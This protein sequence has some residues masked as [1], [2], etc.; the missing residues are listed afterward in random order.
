[1]KTIRIVTI[2]FL[3]LAIKANA[4]HI[5][6]GEIYYDYLGSNNYQ[7]TLKL[8]RDCFAGVAAYDNPANV[9]I[10][11]SNGNLVDSVQIPFPGSVVLP[12][13]ISNPCFTPPSN[14]CVEEAVYQTVVNLPPIAGGYNITYQRCCRNN[15]ILNLINPGDVGST[16]MTHVRDPTIATN[17][18]SPHFINLPPIFLCEGVPFT[19]DHAAVDADGDSLYYELCDPYTGLTS[20]CPILGPLAGTG[21]P[22]VAS[23]PP[24]A[25]VPWL[26][27]Y[28]A[29]NPLSA[30]VPLA[31]NPQ[32]GFMNATPDLIGQW[33]V[34][35]CVSEYRNGVLIS[36][37]K[38]D[39]QFNVVN[40][41]NLP[42]ASIPEQTLFCNGYTVNFNSA[43]LN[44]FSYHW[45]FGDNSITNDTSNLENT[46]WTYA[47]SGQYTV[48]LIINQGTLCVD[49]QTT[50]FL[51]YQPINASFNPPP[52]QCFLSNSF[53]FQGIATTSPTTSYA[54]SFGSS[55]IPDTSNILNP[56]NIVFQTPGTY[57]IT[58]T[59]TQNG[60]TEA[61]T[62]SITV[63]P[64][65][66]AIFNVLTDVFCVLNPVSFVDSSISSTP[67]TYL[68]DF[69]N[70]TTSTLPNP[71]VEYAQ[72][73]VYTPSLVVTSQNNCSDSFIFPQALDVE[74]SPIAGFSLS[75]SV[76][77][78]F[79]AKLVFTDQ[80]SFA[81]NCTIFWGDGTFTSN[82]DTSHQY[83]SPGYYTVMQVV[84]N[85][86]GC[87]DTAILEVEVES[88]FVFWIPNAFTPDKNNLNDVFKP[89]V[90]GVRDYTFS[91]F[92]RWGVK[93]FETSDFTQG[94]DGTYKNAS[95]KMDV[96]N[97]KIVF[98]DNVENS[99][100]QH[101]G[102]VSLLP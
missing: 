48:T 73:G 7:I 43:S 53:D 42:V 16:Y 50:Q 64:Q 17:N 46:Q 44:A 10:F 40:C 9:F 79:D 36:V 34:C 52:D 75:H 15:S 68:W 93:I 61:Y 63:H 86:L 56:T 82:C 81:T 89:T 60:C 14:V 100:H 31:I 8:Y 80:S 87:A 99:F 30:N 1:M 71:V 18:T 95:C 3:L 37:T 23:P 92:D 32:T 90:F 97:Y 45:D 49:T 20:S 65:P 35:V 33:V 39:F 13:S 66:Q 98:K 88:E 69:G 59:L 96:Y 84:E 74:E 5:V 77:S 38:R 11:D 102:K 62:D 25:T 76:L 94:W 85:Q 4:T 57:P 101:I 2:I 19:F 72:Q 29:T 55:A 21:C 51:I 41:P 70:G 27:P 12:S 58:F 47:D 28:S 26:A 54:W 22:Q 78:S 91:I 83:S 24:F 6:G 67:L